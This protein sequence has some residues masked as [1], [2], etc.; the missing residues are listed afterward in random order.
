MSYNRRNMVTVSAFH[1]TLGIPTLT[2]ISNLTGLKVSLENESYSN[3][4]NLALV[5]N[6]FLYAYLQ[7]RKKKCFYTWLIFL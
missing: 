4:N 2:I 6:S 7:M 5:A 1:T 3:K